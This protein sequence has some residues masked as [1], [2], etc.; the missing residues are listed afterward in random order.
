[1][2]KY[3]IL[4]VLL[5]CTAISNR[6]MAQYIQAQYCIGGNADD[7]IWEVQKTKDKGAMV[8]VMTAS[9]DSGMPNPDKRKIRLIKLNNSNQIEWDKGYGDAFLNLTSV[10]LV[11]HQYHYLITLSTSD[12]DLGAYKSR[13][14]YIDKDGNQKFNIVRDGLANLYE[15]NVLFLNN[16]SILFSVVEDTSVVIYNIDSTGSTVWSDTLVY[17]MLYRNVTDVQVINVSGVQL[18]DNSIFLAVSLT[19]RNPIFWS[20]VK[21]TEL[22]QYSLAGNILRRRM[23]DTLIE[24]S[25]SNFLKEDADQ[26]YFSNANEIHRIN[27]STL[28]QRSDTLKGNNISIVDIASHPGI[29]VDSTKL[30][31]RFVNWIPEFD[32]STGKTKYYI[33]RYDADDFRIAYKTLF[34]STSNTIQE[35][36]KYTLKDHSTLILYKS[37]GIYRLLKLDKEGNILFN[38]NYSGKINPTDYIEWWANTFPNNIN[39]L[40]TYVNGVRISGDKMYSAFIFGS[41]D[42][43][44]SRVFKQWLFIHDLITGEEEFAYLNNTTDS[45]LIKYIAPYPDENGKILLVSDLYGGN[46]CR[47]GGF[48]IQLTQLLTT[49]NSIY[50]AAYIDYNNNSTYDGNDVLY[51]LAMINSEKSGSRS[52]SNYMY[53][54]LYTRNDVDTGRWT[55]QI[56]L[57]AP[58]F[59]ITP[60]SRVTEHADYGYKDTIL[61]ALRPNDTIQDLSVNLVNT[62]VTRLG[63]NSQYEITYA[64]Y[65]THPVN[66]TIKL[67]MDRRLNYQ[68]SN[69]APV[70]DGDT[71]SWNFNNLNANDFRKIT[72]VATADI[73][74]FLN[75]NDTLILTTWVYGVTSRIDTTP[76]DNKKVLKDV[77]MGAF[78]PNDK[79]S[80]TETNITPA[81]VENGD[82]ISYVIRFQNI[83]NDTAFKVVILDTLDA[84]LDWGSFEMVNASHAFSVQLLN[85]NIL[86]F[87]SNNLQLPPSSVDEYGSHGFVAYKLKPKKTM[88]S[89]KSV[90]NT[91]HIYFDFNTPVMTN[92]VITNVLLL[93]DAGK[94][95]VKKSGYKLYPNPNTGHFNIE[96]YAPYASPLKIVLYDINGRMVFQQE[97]QHRYS[98]NI[99]FSLNGIASGLYNLVLITEQET[100][101][102]KLVVE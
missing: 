52:V 2:K 63:K 7:I 41:L 93:S 91:A 29:D 62:F 9:V 79:Y 80:T 10:Q 61:F 73:P 58:Y 51:R 48:D 81:Q 38:R 56:Q 1:M 98:S 92:K 34:D 53:G 97:I 78:D 33:V 101:S 71:L 72:I 54:N 59:T 23:S 6:L 66:G 5:F 27:K 83:G 65:G 57:T 8:L 16:G 21:K 77:V 94:N 11:Q 25:F 86:K 44:G 75:V 14:F 13:I 76:L 36:L 60:A 90:I 82:Y 28:E 43:L 42:S 89:G 85:G 74:P 67:K 70:L 96:F 99:P 64:N 45:A 37:D 18:M 22:L 31:D 3:L 50:G 24:Y 40:Y 95:S 20:N 32:S 88:S 47:L 46:T 68:F 15:H 55:T 100:V 49:T 102:S 19:S 26:L 12:R 4:S 69:P 87:S 30:V 84:N 39:I 35:A 17:K